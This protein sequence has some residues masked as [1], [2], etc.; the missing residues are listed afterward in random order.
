VPL[1]GGPAT[2]RPRGKRGHRP[3]ERG[4]HERLRLDGA[5]PRFLDNDHRQRRRQRQWCGS[6]LDLAEHRR[7]TSG[8]PH[9]RWGAGYRHAARN[10]RAAPG[11]AH[12]RAG[13]CTY[14][15]SRTGAQSRTGTGFVTEPSSFAESRARADAHTVAQSGACADAH[16]GALTVPHTVADAEPV[17][18]ANSDPDRRGPTRWPREVA[19][20]IVSGPDIH[21]RRNDRL[22]R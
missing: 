12:T 16:S 13:A 4:H 8:C 22:R 5:R 10:Y 2:R 9:D 1:R 14:P 6:T 11:P 15:D 17:A 20:R 21:D 19:Q 3:G 18:A 7:L